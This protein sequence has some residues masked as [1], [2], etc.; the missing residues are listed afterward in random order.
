M[1]RREPLLTTAEAAAWF[2]GVQGKRP[3]VE[4]VRR[5][6]TEGVRGVR[7]ECEFVGAHRHY[8]VKALRRFVEALQGAEA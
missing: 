5:W 4:T 8:R 6:T 7:L 3:H 2:E 1:A